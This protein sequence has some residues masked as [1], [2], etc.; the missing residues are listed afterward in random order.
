MVIGIVIVGTCI[1]RDSD[2][3]LKAHANA[4][5]SVVKN[6]QR[7]NPPT[8]PQQNELIIVQDPNPQPQMI[9]MGKF[10]TLKFRTINATNT[11][12]VY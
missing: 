7:A 12:D 11:N 9:L 2:K 4:L 6:N 3:N 8:Q 1:K 5:A 10:S